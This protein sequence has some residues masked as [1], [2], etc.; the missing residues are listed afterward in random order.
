MSETVRD[1][2]G[3]GFKYEQRKK[4][5]TIT[6]ALTGL[7][8]AYV[9]GANW[10][11]LGKPT[12]VIKNFEDYFGV[13]LTKLD[14]KDS[15][16]I[17][18]EDFLKY[19]SRIWFTRISDGT[20]QKA[21][22][23]LT[24][25]AEGAVLTGNAI[26][27]KLSYIIEAGKN[28]LTINDDGVPKNVTLTPTP[29]ASPIASVDLSAFKN[30]GTTPDGNFDVGAYIEF[31]I[32]G[33][34]YQHFVGTK[35]TGNTVPHFTEVAADSDSAS[36]ETNFGTKS[37]AERL[38]GAIKQFILIPAGVTQADADKIITVNANVISFNSLLVGSASSVAI[39]AFPKLFT[40]GSTTQA[41]D[42][43]IENIVAQIDAALTNS[44]AYINSD[45]KITIATE[46]VGST[47]AVGIT[48][49]A[50]DLVNKLGLVL[51]STA[52]GKDPQ[53]G[54]GI[55]QAKYTGIDGNTIKLVK[56]AIDGGYMLMVYFREAII[57]TFVNY[58]Y[59][60]TSANFIG[61]LLSND[62]NCSEVLEYIAPTLPTGV[63]SIEPFQYG[64]IELAGGAS[65]IVNINDNH[66]IAAIDEYKN[67]DLYDVDVLCVSG[68]VSQSVADKLQEVCEYRQ[69]CWSI[70]DS[71]E[72]ISG[73][74]AGNA[75]V[76]STINWHNG[77][78]G[79]RTK[80]LNS[81]FVATYFPWIKIDKTTIYNEAN[82]KQWYAP[83]T[84]VMGAIA[85]SYKTAKCSA[86][87]GH[88]RA[89]INDIIDLAFY[90]GE[91]EK[92]K[93]YG[94][95]YGNA[96][97]PIVYNRALGFFIDGA[98]NTDRELGAL[99]RLNVLMTSLFIKRDIAN[100]APN[101]F[102]RELT[103]TTLNDFYAD[104]DAIAKNYVKI[105]A[106]KADYTITVDTEQNSAEVE[107][108][109]GLIGAIEW[110][111]IRAIEKIKVISTIR[112]Q[113]YTVTYQ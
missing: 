107:A 46:D 67:L 36:W 18:A 14:G 6:E 98:K 66:Y 96:I 23:A 7:I 88:K 45:G 50:P 20:A 97:N 110:E 76:Y 72:D 85:N 102:W 95:E 104:L 78:G 89:K 53:V 19:S 12:Y 64:T 71:P 75:A 57:A 40:A 37:Y 81:R 16:G 65:G 13:P 28:T 34:I 79:G 33:K 80:K 48:A 109:N 60:T 52:S 92:A 41:V 61:A 108:S 103:T 111:G 31:K 90:L 82:G 47:K 73:L 70:I 84:R 54:G 35:P 113:K 3:K 106:I 22:K 94:D 63:T 27:S 55:F 93:L 21:Y 62:T 91:P 42:T 87:A 68:N 39:V 32:D 69:D 101:Y 112:D 30:D 43:A 25:P 15:S 8:G 5:T 38:A 59:D 51:D 26:V 105:N 17:S 24:K 58:S 9:G 10:G 86:P 4:V 74:A 44:I 29:A 11:P 49:I 83:S 77:A 1:I 56:S 2:P 100:I 99:S